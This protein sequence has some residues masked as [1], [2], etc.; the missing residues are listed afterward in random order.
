MKSISIDFSAEEMEKISA[1]IERRKERHITTSRAAL[2]REAAM[3]WLD[4]Q[5]VKHDINSTD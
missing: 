3:S 2:I 1:E 5:E 4:L